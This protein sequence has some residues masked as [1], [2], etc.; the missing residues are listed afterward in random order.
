MAMSSAASSASNRGWGT[1]V[2]PLTTAATSVRRPIVW[3]R[4]MTPRT[5]SPGR[6]PVCSRCATEEACSARCVRGT[7]FGRPVVPE[8]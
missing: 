2:P 5:A 3:K 1:H 4:G 7:P 8:V 6:P